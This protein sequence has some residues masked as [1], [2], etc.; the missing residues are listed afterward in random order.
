MAIPNILVLQ[1]GGT[2]GQVRNSKGVLNPSQRDYLHLIR[3]ISLKRG[4]NLSSTKDRVKLYENRTYSLKGTN[5]SPLIHFDAL[6]TAN[7]DSTNM[8][9][10]QRADIAKIIYKNAH[11]YDGFVVIHGTDS[12]A[13]SGAAL[14][15]ML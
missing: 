13:D 10:S 8:E 4:Q 7:I 2:I 15:L 5:T 9:T 6:Q 3:G 11:D 12:M 1:T 14:P